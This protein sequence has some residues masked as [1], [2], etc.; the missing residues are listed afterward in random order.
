M[1]IDFNL[2]SQFEMILHNPISQKRH[3]ARFT[4]QHEKVLFAE[5]VTAKG[6]LYSYFKFLVAV[7]CYK[8]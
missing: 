4:V 1:V 7:F 5:K 6:K 8:L 2:F 3:F